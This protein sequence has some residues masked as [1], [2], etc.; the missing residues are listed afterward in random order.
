MKNKWKWIVALL[1]AVLL[2]VPAVQTAHA[3]VYRQGSRGQTVKTIQ[4]KLKD[5]GYYKGSVDGVFG[6]ET[7]KA[8]KYFQSKNGLTADGV[9]G[10][11]TLKALG[12]QVSGTQ[13]TGAGAGYSSDMALMARM[14]SAEAR[15]EPYTGQVA[16]GAVIL[17]RVKHP[18]FPDTI[19][20]VIYQKGAFSAL[21]DGQ[22]DQPVSDSA[23]KAAQDAMNGWDPT[24]GAIY[25]YNPAKTTNKWIWSRPVITT[26]GK[27]VFAK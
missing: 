5:W 18:S 25:Y 12:M 1:V 2:V 22:F 7:K 15:G 24:G 23:R 11:K 26:I 13:N 14:I 19:A 21:D 27:H 10:A 3:A 20:G 8:V 9:V 17:N 4:T 6:A 16:V